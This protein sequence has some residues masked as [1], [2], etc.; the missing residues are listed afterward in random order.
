[1]AIYVSAVEGQFLGGVDAVKVVV[2][3]QMYSP[4]ENNTNAS[5][6]PRFR[7]QA[8]AYLIR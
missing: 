1:M 2:A 7:P 5:A 4:F 8:C 3:L 6:M